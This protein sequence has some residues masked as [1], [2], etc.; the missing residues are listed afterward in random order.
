VRH[1][2]AGCQSIDERRRFDERLVWFCDPHERI[3]HF[4]MAGTAEHQS[5]SLTKLSRPRCLQI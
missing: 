3:R 5:I 2:R 4:V 1:D